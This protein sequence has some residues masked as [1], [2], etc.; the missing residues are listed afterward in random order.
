MK[1]LESRKFSSLEKYSRTSVKVKPS[2]LSE[3]DDLGVTINSE[4]LEST[5]PIPSNV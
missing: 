5:P 3:V 1:L 2:Q 4:S